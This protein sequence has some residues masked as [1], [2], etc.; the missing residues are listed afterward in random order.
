[1]RRSCRQSSS[2][3][4]RSSRC[5]R[6]RSAQTG[7]AQ[8]SNHTKPFT[9]PCSINLCSCDATDACLYTLIYKGKGLQGNRVTDQVNSDVRTLTD[10][11]TVEGN[12]AFKKRERKSRDMKAG[13]APLKGKG[14]CLMMYM[15]TRHLKTQRHNNRMYH[16]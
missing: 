2:T 4:A 1:M 15:H 3:C 12:F 6:R 13:R 9:L 11:L 7:A 14:G 16:L 5:A 8:S 10:G